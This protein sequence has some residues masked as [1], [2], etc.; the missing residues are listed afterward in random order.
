[1]SHLYR[2]AM[3]SRIS[4]LPTLP[5]VEGDEKDESLD[6]LGSLPSS[7]GPPALQVR[8]SAPRS[9]EPNPLF[10]PISAAGFFD[11]AFQISVAESG[12]EFRVYYTPPKADSGTVIVCHHGAGCSGL[13]FATFAKE[14]ARI[15]KGEC[16][17]LAYDCRAHGKTTSLKSQTEPEDLSINILIHDLAHLIA[18]VFPKV[19]KA[20]TLLLVGHS[21]GG[22]VIVGACPV[23]QANKYKL[24]GV[25][26]IDVVEEFTLEALPM[27]HSL[28]DSRPEG[29][30]SQEDAVEWHFK[31][32]AIR[33]SESARVSVPSIVKKN[34]GESGPAY[35][36]RTPLRL[37]APYWDGWFTGLSSKFLAAR[38]ARLLVLAGT[39]RLDKELMIGQMQ[40]R[41]QLSVIPNVGH[42]VQEDDPAYLAEVVVEFWQ[43]NERVTV[44]I[45]KVGEL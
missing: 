15:G 9:R 8:F 28:L 4:K 14:V 2:S 27:M 6:S 37:T 5:P 30:A 32:Q 22:A 16:G 17:L 43:R 29:F 19:E 23:L 34:E 26:V 31:T 39:E 11:Q 38:A 44:G 21:L 20:P 35:I 40:G 7:M 10:A 13:T 1:M 24:T 18:T 25:V 12:L 41:Y 42:M 33:N 36:W 3:H 45:K